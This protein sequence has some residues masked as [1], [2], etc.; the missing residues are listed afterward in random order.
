M[1]RLKFTVL[2]SH[3]LTIGGY[4]NQKNSKSELTTI[5]IDDVTVGP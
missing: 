3:T 1:T 5:L 2:V 4:N